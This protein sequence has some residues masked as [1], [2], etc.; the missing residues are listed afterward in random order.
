MG[1][2]RRCCL[3]LGLSLSLCACDGAK[4]GAEL[5]EIWH[6]NDEG[7]FDLDLTITS[8]A[9]DGRYLAVVGEGLFHGK[10][11]GVKVSFR[12]SMTP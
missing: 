7:W 6:P 11:V 8:V 2:L 9:E 3:A 10:K 4:G 12:E 1:S 5:N